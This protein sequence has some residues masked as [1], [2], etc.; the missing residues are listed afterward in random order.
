MTELGEHFFRLQ[1]LSATIAGHTPPS[2]S[3]KD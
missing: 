2:N 1:L 3:S